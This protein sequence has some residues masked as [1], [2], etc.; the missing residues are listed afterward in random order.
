[1]SATWKTTT[2]NIS[3]SFIIVVYSYILLNHNCFC[4]LITH[5]NPM[6]H[7]YSP[8]KPM[9]FRKYRNVT[10]DLTLSWRRPYHVE[11]SPLIC[12][13]IQ[14]TGFYMISASVMKGLTLSG[15]A[16]VLGMELVGNFRFLRRNQNFYTPA[17]HNVK[18]GDETLLCTTF[19]ILDLLFW[20]IYER[21][22]WKIVGTSSLLPTLYFICLFMNFHL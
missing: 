7:F 6:S 1:M 15:E 4:G 11:T 3:C 17:V 21:L 2:T 14:W 22:L 13:A 9:V 16:W 20:K 8:W 18:D 12:G 19:A 10:L 5:F